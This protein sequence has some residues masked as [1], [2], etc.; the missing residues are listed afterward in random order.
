MDSQ[1]QRLRGKI[2]IVTG[3]SR[4]IGLAIAERLVAEGARVCLTARGEDA[5]ADA[6]ATFP[7]GAAIGVAGHAD[8]ANHRAQVLDA[9]VREFG[10]LD[11]LVNNAGINPAYGPLESADLDAARKILDVNVL[12]TLAWTQG[13]LGHRGLHFRERRG[14]VVN[15]SS[16]S[17]Q[18]PAAGIGLYGISKAA[19]SH[20]TRTLAAELAPEIR[21]N[22][23]A[24][25][26]V[27]TKFASAL[28]EGREEQVAASYPLQRLGTPDDVASAVA[29]L[30]CADA[31]WIT[32]QVLV[33]DGGLLNTSSIG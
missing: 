20:L 5:L 1:C 15:V 8:E 27:K 6:V 23:V 7:A 3:A 33:L 25:A 19:V 28:Y 10:G 16:V 12:A 17:A 32:G 11:I 24:P 18:V 26:V 9:V 30:A 2:A 4:G 29:F 22:A 14:T 31:S 13:A 21:V